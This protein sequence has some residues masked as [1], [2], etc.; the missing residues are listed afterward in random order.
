M[1]STVPPPF[2]VDNSDMEEEETQENLSEDRS[3]ETVVPPLIT[4]RAL[5]S[6]DVA[7][8]ALIKARSSG[9]ISQPVKRHSPL[10]QPS[11]RPRRRRNRLVERDSMF[12]I[13]F[14]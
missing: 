10:A 12:Q 9:R 1:N 8:R 2:S 3:I 7:Y 11:E 14:H 6:A 4:V 13:P 5:T